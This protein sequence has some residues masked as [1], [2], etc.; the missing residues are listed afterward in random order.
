MFAPVLAIARGVPVWVWA[1]VACLIWGGFNF[2]RAKTQ[3]A[4]RAVA[5]QA[6]AVQAV[7]AAEQA[8]A[9]EREA[10]LNEAT[11]K[12]ANAYRSDLARRAAAAAAVRADRDRLLDAVAATPGA[13]AATPGAAAASGIDGAAALRVVVRE[14]TAALSQVAEAAD[15]ADARLIGLQ[16]YVRATRP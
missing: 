15:A 7:A 1:L 13:C 9:R 5:E 6:A 16:D 8:K 12:A 11:R 4:A 2:H 10:E 3:T 14:C